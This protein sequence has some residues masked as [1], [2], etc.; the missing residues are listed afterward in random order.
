MKVLVDMDCTMVDFIGA[1]LKRYNEK[2]SSDLSVEDITQWVLPEDLVEIYKNTP[3]FFYRLEPFSGVI[4]GM[5]KLAKYHDV[6]VVTDPS[7]CPTIEMQ[8]RAWMD[9]FLP[10][11]P[12]IFTNDKNKYGAQVIIDD[13]PHHLNSFTGRLKVCVDWPW[14]RDVKAD[15]RV[16]PGFDWDDLTQIIN[17]LE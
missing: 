6:F 8:K 9:L 15:V 17:N 2:Y 12:I 5:R 10:E 4:H 13:A 7:G 3:D 11:I 1:L 16:T 14:N